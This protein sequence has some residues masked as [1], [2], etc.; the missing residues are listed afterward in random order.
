MTDAE[1]ISIYNE[2]AAKYNDVM[3]L[4]DTCNCNGGEHDDKARIP[5]FDPDA[6]N[7]HSDL[8]E[9]VYFTTQSDTVK[10]VRLISIIDKYC[11]DLK[12]ISLKLHGPLDVYHPNGYVQLFTEA[13][14]DPETGSHVDA[15]NGLGIDYTDN[16][17]LDL[18]RLNPAPDSSEFLE[19]KVYPILNTQNQDDADSLADAALDTFHEVAAMPK[20]CAIDGSVYEFNG[21]LTYTID[22][23]GTLNAK[24]TIESEINDIYDDLIDYL[25]NDYANWLNDDTSTLDSDIDTLENTY[26]TAARTLVVSYS[27]SASG[28]G[29]ATTYFPE[30][31]NY[32]SDYIDAITPLSEVFYYKPGIEYRMH[33]D[34]N[35]G[36][37]YCT[38]VVIDPIHLRV[39]KVNNKYQVDMALTGL[40]YA[41]KHGSISINGPTNHNL[42]LTTTVRPREYN[43]LGHLTSISY[44]AYSGVAPSCDSLVI[45]SDSSQSNPID[46]ISTFPTLSWDQYDNMLVAPGTYGPAVIYNGTTYLSSNATLTD[47]EYHGL[48]ICAE[49]HLILP[50]QQSGE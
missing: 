36:T 39:A 26:T 17:C 4:Y 5:L 29:I 10:G 19:A 15:P 35:S 31:A 11:D 46:S 40:S 50:T 37:H 20:K 18:N 32:P 42:P 21:T 14:L 43:I 38:K 24:N 28:G 22:N 2:M 44:S 47:P 33:I 30:N 41:Y 49:P 23:T 48:I 8:K 34:H 7:K 12:D 16:V 1:A 9:I 45:S 13:Q 6:D 25:K 3:A 27:T